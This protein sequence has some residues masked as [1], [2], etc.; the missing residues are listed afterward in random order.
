MLQTDRRTNKWTNGQGQSLR[1][2]LK[3]RFPKIGYAQQNLTYIANTIFSQISPML[4]NNLSTYIDLPLFKSHNSGYHVHKIWKLQ[5]HYF[6]SF[7][8]A[9]GNCWLLYATKYPSKKLLKNIYFQ[10]YL[11]GFTLAHFCPLLLLIFRKGHP[12]LILLE[13]NH[14][15]NL[16]ENFWIE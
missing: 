10:C 15:L 9:W 4:W 1:P 12:Y 7:G 14:I 6:S 3:D 16:S 5:F 8:E 2:M 13:L 11:L